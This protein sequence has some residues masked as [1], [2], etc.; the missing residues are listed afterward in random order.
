[1]WYGLKCSLH[2]YLHGQDGG[3]CHFAL[4]L[5]YSVI[6]ANKRDKKYP[7][8]C[9]HIIKYWV[10][11]LPK[12]PNSPIRFALIN[13]NITS[14]PSQKNF[15][16]YGYLFSQTTVALDWRLSSDCK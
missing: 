2:W 13:A 12:W 15:L 1:M 14:S 11:N 8:S 16:V 5:K 10:D 9:Y 7:S 4:T 3:F 6:P